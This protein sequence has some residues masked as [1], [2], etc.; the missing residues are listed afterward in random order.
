M[1]CTNNILKNFNADKNIINVNNY[2]NKVNLAQ[3]KNLIDQKDSNVE[4]L[5]LNDAKFCK[6]LFASVYEKNRLA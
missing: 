5:N 1:F 2:L 6:T 4:P 3:N